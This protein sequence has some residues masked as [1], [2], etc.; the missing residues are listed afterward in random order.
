MSSFTDIQHIIII[1]VLTLVMWLVK[2]IFRSLFSRRVVPTNS[3]SI[4]V[5]LPIPQQAQSNQTNIIMPTGRS[6]SESL[7]IQAFA[8]IIQE[9]GGDSSLI[10][11]GIRLPCII[12]PETG[13][14]L[15]FDAYYEPWKLA[16]EY[17]GIQHYEFPNRF[18]ANTP[19]GRAT[20]Q[21]QLRRD[22]YKLQAARS[23]GIHVI[24][25]PYHVDTCQPCETSPTHYKYDPKITK[26]QRLERLRC[27][28]RPHIVSHRR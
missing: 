21:S 20:F 6:T 23:N 27:F 17:N 24:S 3:T 25:I 7:A 22:Q 1:L 13:R 10:K 8:Q 16:M 12:N 2:R 15:E 4:P 28:I 18:H 26:V 19:I 14:R 11:V 9:Y 5:P